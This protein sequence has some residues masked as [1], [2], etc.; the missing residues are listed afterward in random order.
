MAWDASPDPTYVYNV[1]QRNPDTSRTFLGGTANTAYFVSNLNRVD[2]EISTTLEVEAVGLEFGH[3][4][5]V[6]T[7]FY[8]DD[9]GIL[10][11]DGF[12]SGT[13]SSWTSAVP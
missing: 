10:F 7:L 5:A 11:L 12:E 13:T 9:T 3:S 1:Y 4:T 8:W 2:D 6:E